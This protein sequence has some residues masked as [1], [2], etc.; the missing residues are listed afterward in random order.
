MIDDR[1]CPVDGIMT[2]FMP[3]IDGQSSMAII[4]S[5]FKFPEGSEVHIQCDIVQCNGKCPVEDKC[6]GDSFTKNGRNLGQTEDGLLLAATTVY[7]LDPADAPC[8]LRK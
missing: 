4:N 7:V 2:R 6:D 8:K 1:G 5:M 3:S